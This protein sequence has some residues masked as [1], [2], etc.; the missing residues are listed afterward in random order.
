[1]DLAERPYPTSY[2]EAV[3]AI[4]PRLEVPREQLAPLAT[5]PKIIE[6]LRLA[7]EERELRSSLDRATVA[8]I[9]ATVETALP[10]TVAEAE[11][12]HARPVDPVE[13]F[14]FVGTRYAARTTPDMIAALRAAG[15]DDL[16]ILDLA[17]AIADANHWA[18]FHRLVGLP[19]RLLYVAPLA[20]AQAGVPSRS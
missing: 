13:A 18:R 4:A 6:A 10:R 15:Y 1:M 16:G 9:Q 3:A 8:R 7:L 2:D 19:P 5:R 20:R 12:F 14:A 11:G 17:T